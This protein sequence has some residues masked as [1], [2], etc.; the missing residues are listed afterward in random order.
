[1]KSIAIIAIRVVQYKTVRTIY[2]FSSTGYVYLP[3][4][5]HRKKRFKLFTN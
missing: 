2:G 3:N 4:N 5:L 1:M